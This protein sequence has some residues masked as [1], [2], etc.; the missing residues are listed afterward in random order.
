MQIARFISACIGLFD[1]DSFAEQAQQVVLEKPVHVEPES[2]KPERDDENVKTDVR[3]PL[4]G[5]D[6]ESNSYLVENYPY[7]GLRTQIRFWLEKS[8]SKGFRFASQTKNPKT[9]RWNNP[10][11]STY[12]SLGGQMYLDDNDHVKWSGVTEYSQGEAVEKFLHHFPETDKSLLKTYILIQI[13]YYK[14]LVASNEMGLSGYSYGGIPSPIN[15]DDLEKNKKQLSCWRRAAEKCGIVERKETQQQIQVTTPE[16]KVLS[17]VKKQIPMDVQGYL[18]AIKVEFLNNF[19]D[20]YFN[21]SI[22]TLGGKDV[23]IYLART[24]KSGWPNGII[25]NDILYHQIWLS[26]LFAYEDGLN[27][28]IVAEL[29]LGGSIL[30]KNWNRVKIGWAKKTGDTQKIYSH[31]SK[32]FQK[33]REVYDSTYP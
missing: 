4:Y 28:K 16:V 14:S 15:P 3:Q 31:L 30:D 20:G 6:S 19:P 24:K 27:D 18:D 12:C 22:N 33:M 10:K 25:N 1:S 2:I 11:T 26:N 9:L 7:G 21:P 8:N 23:C 29:S 17:T 13:K 32:Y 5:Y